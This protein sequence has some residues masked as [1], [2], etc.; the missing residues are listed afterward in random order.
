MRLA[1]LAVAAVLL[2]S[3]FGCAGLPASPAASNQSAAGQASPAQNAGAG[4]APAGGAGAGGAGV[5]AGVSFN[6]WTA[7][8]NSVTLQV[9]SGWQASEKQV[10]NCT[11]NWAV[12]DPAGTSSAYMQNEVIVLKSE[13]ARQLYKPYVANIGQVPVAG[14]L[15]AE[16]ATQQIIA[17]LTGT[18]DV[19]IT[20][21]DD[22]LSR[23]FSQAV[24]APGLA[25]CDAQ[26]FEAAYQRDGI[27]MRGFYLVQ[28]YDFGEGTTWWINIWGYTSPAA[29][30]NA[31]SPTLEKTFTSVRYT[32]AWA[33]RCSA[34]AANASGLIGD[35]V[36]GRQAASDSA[37]QAWDQ[38]ILGQ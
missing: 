3:I 37:A 35:V 2:F 25:A 16:Q 19:H 30:W 34:G 21:R 27:L 38:Y 33:G 32:D 28:T 31:S 26:A 13:N 12:T 1:I 17:P 7:P 6:D 9:P 8:D 36:A 23:Q 14:Y 24:C 10:D 11:V 20:Y 15:M 29:D 4:A 18:S 5:P 22:A